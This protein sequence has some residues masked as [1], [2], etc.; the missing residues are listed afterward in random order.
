[1]APHTP[2][3]FPG[4][5]AEF[6]TANMGRAA[7]Q[8]RAMLGQATTVAAG[9]GLEYDFDNVKHSNTNLAHQLLHFAKTQGK[10]PALIEVLFSSYF[11]KGRRVSGVEDLVPL[12][13]E[14][15]LDGEGA[16]AALETEVYAGGVEDDIA[17]AQAY[18]I[19]SVPF[20]VFNSKYGVSGAQ[21]TAAFL[22]VLEELRSPIR[23]PHGY[24]TAPHRQFSSLS[25]PARSQCFPRRGGR[26]G[27][28]PSRLA[29]SH[30]GVARERAPP[31]H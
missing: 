3:D 1:M 24:C 6:L 25:Q 21:E 16:R 19:T 22:E 2:A 29:A 9:E 7:E 12:A 17:Q 31:Q 11:E 26:T 28:G 30:D 18:G 20:F 8:V 14:A 23:F 13:I 10:Q 4:T 27:L 15:G 5:E